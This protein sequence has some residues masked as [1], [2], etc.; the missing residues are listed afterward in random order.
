MIFVDS[1][2]L[3]FTF[4]PGGENVA[5]VP[6]ENA[7][8]EA[9]PFVS[10]CMLV[11]DARRFLSLL[12]CLRSAPDKAGNPTNTLEPSLV[13]ILRQRGSKSST[14]YEASKDSVL[15]SLIEEGLAKVNKSAVSR[16]QRIVKFRVLPQDFTQSGGEDKIVVVVVVIDFAAVVAVFADHFLLLSRSTGFF[17]RC[18]FGSGIQTCD[19]TVD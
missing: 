16:A 18:F 12:I 8:L 10:N 19:V 1:F 9:M 14:I 17:S 7:V 3:F 6:I 11:G 13:E 2:C 5:P 4:V 15:H